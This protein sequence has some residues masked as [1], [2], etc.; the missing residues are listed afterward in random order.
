M[1][2]ISILFSG[3]P[4]STLAALYALQ[5]AD[6][7]HLITYHHR[8]MSHDKLISGKP[9]SSTVVQELIKNYG[10]SRIVVFNQDIWELFKKIYFH[11]I[12]ISLQNYGS[13]CIPWICGACKLAMHVKSIEYDLKNNI[14]TTYDGANKESAAVFPAQNKNYVRIMQ[15]LYESYGMTYDTPV[16]DIEN[17]DIKTEEFGLESCKGTKQEHVFFSTQHSCFSGLLLHLHSRLYYKLMRKS[18]LFEELTSKVLS[19]KIDELKTLLPNKP[20]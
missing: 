4:D 16:Y 8:L 12:F 18:Y 19:A 9:K 11:N 5:K 10:R 13:F 6:R 20:Q 1:K 15:E 14:Q 3:G 7:I 2:E 17:T